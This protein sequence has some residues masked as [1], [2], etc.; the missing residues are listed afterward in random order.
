LGDRP[1]AKTAEETV[2]LTAES[3][4]ASLDQPHA[5]AAG[6]HDRALA[7]AA[8]DDVLPG[9]KQPSAISGAW[10]RDLRV[11][12]PAI[13]QWG[14]VAVITAMEPHELDELQVPDLGPSPV[15]SA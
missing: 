6:R 14:A 4:V 15:S 2:C 8:G 5:P 9:K 1:G 3:F 13:R 12:P 10:D 7:R 11:D